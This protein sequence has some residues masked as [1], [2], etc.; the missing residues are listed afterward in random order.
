MADPFSTQATEGARLLREVMGKRARMT[1]HDRV[2][3]TVM[4]DGALERAM[5]K[6]RNRCFDLVTKLRAGLIMPEDELD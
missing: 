1:K 5:M 6:E 4:I 2:L 3:L